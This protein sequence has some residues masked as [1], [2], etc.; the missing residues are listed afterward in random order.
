VAWVGLQPEVRLSSAPPRKATVPFV[1]PLSSIPER[2]HVSRLPGPASFPRPDI[3]VAVQG[4]SR[5]APASGRH[6]A[7]PFA[8][9]GRVC[10]VAADGVEQ[11]IVRHRWLRTSAARSRPMKRLRCDTLAEPHAWAQAFTSKRLQQITTLPFSQL[12][13]VNRR[14]GCPPT[15]FHL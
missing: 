4:V 14:D 9:A 10:Q 8:G 6:L 13:G 5:R 11:V 7:M 1:G 12:L 3:R 15:R 2:A